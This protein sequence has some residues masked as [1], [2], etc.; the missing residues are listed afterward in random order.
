MPK[1]KPITE[2]DV[3][4]ILKSVNLEYG[5]PADLPSAWLEM[6]PKDK[7]AKAEEQKPGEKK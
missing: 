3:K 4:E 5:K 7:E 6:M 2:K 1:P